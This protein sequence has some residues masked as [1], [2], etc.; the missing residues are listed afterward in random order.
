VRISVESFDDGMDSIMSKDLDDLA[1]ALRD[2]PPDRDLEA[3]EPLVWR[4]LDDDAG[5]A[6]FGLAPGPSLAAARLSFGAL[7]LMAG[8]AAG[9]AL[10]GEAPGAADEL[11]V[12]RAAAPFAPS[13]LLT[14]S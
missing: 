6:F 5:W 11:A 7:A 12:F 9:V 4:R 1:R 13:T 14:R 10:G 8:L 3:I 2:I